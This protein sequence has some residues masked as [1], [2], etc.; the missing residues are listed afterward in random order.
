MHLMGPR[1][2]T[3]V[4]TCEMSDLEALWHS[5][6][7]MPQS[8]SLS[9][10][11][12]GKKEKNTVKKNN[13]PICYK[14]AS[15]WGLG[16]GTDRVTYIEKLTMN[17]I[18]CLG[19][20]AVLK[21]KK[22]NLW[23]MRTGLTH[24]TSYKPHGNSGLHSER[25]LSHTQFIIHWISCISQSQ[26]QPSNYQSK[27]KLQHLSALFQ[28][29]SSPKGWKKITLTS[30]GINADLCEWSPSRSESKIFLNDI[31]RC[32]LWWGYSG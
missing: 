13:N 10:S 8:P 29:V 7:N 19:L 11:F 16:R 23:L 14:W 24:A 28:E 30:S 4:F 1:C 26:S 17:S 32:S 12:C 15:G 31:Q 6:K 27:G 5:I 20:A 22:M 3:G 2:I 25:P 21:D 9:F 18:H